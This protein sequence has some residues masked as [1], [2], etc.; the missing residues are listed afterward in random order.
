MILR[1]SSTRSRKSPENKSA[2]FISEAAI[3]ILIL[4]PGVYAN[5]NVTDIVPSLSFQILLV[6]VSRCKTARTL[7]SHFCI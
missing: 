3:Q 6:V 1:A 4:P 5:V 2:Q 7:T